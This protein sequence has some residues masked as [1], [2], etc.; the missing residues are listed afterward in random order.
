MARGVESVLAFSLQHVLPHLGDLFLCVRL[1]LFLV[2][3]RNLDF[4]F[5]CLLSLHFVRQ[6]LELGVQVHRGLLVSEERPAI[7][8]VARTDGVEVAH[9]ILQDNLACVLKMSRERLLGS[10][11][12]SSQVVVV[13]TDHVLFAG[14][15]EEL[16]I[17]G[18]PEICRLEICDSVLLTHHWNIALITLRVNAKNFQLAG[19]G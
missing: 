16:S 5:L 15:E 19:R 2:K 8:A 1:Q 13:D 17:R 9:V 7:D 14:D 12:L 6:H 4:A 10:D 11:H 3:G 18:E